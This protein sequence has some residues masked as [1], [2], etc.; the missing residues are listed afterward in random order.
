MGYMKIMSLIISHCLIIDLSRFIYVSQGEICIIM[1]KILFH[2]SCERERPEGAKRR[3]LP[4][5]VQ[6]KIRIHKIV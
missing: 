2:G 3:W 6:F 4:S 5:T 1:N